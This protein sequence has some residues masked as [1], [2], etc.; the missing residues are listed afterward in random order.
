MKKYMWEF[1]NKD[2]ET[3]DKLLFGNYNPDM[4][5][6]G[7]RRF[8]GLT[9][10]GISELLKGGFI[11]PREKLNGAPDVVKIH[12]FMEKY[13]A[14]TAHGYAVSLKR[15]DYRISLSGVAKNRTADSVEEK[16]DFDYLFGQAQTITY[17]PMYCK[18]EG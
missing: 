17:N 4:Y 7:I 14:Y 2:E 8:A 10:A 16:K 12:M 6:G 13:P 11:N 9:A 15:S 1:L 3:R 18:F 5:E